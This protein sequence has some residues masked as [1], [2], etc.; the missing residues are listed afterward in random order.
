MSSNNIRSQIM[1]EQ[2]KDIKYL[3]QDEIGSVIAK[4]L[5]STYETRPKNPIEYFAKW[6]LNYRQ[7]EREAQ[8]VSYNF[9][10]LIQILFSF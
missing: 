2:H 6:L 1:G 7:T 8:N 4:G 10:Y 3:M 5:S 9:S